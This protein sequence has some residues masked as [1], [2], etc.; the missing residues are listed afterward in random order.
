MMSSA[1]DVLGLAGRIRADVRMTTA[2]ASDDGD[3]IADFLVVWQTK[4]K[5]LQTK[6]EYS[7]G[8]NQ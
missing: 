8:R 5:V 3:I 6:T 2:K 1:D 4:K 7:L